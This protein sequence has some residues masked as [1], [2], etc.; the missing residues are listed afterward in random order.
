[1]RVFTYGSVRIKMIPTFCRP[2]IWIITKSRILKVWYLTKSYEVRIIVGY[3]SAVHIM[4]QV[5]C[6]LII[7]VATFI[8]Q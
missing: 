7:V 5:G 8:G 2:A 6:D 4:C 1:M 3:V